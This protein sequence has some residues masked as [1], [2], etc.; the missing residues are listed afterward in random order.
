MRDLLAQVSKEVSGEWDGER[1]VVQPSQELGATF[2]R[3]EDT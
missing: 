3:R 2:K 1:G